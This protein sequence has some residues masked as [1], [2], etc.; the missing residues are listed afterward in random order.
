MVGDVRQCGYMVGI[1]LVK[2]R[3]HQTPF[4]LT[5]RIGHHVSM[6]ARRRGLLIRPIGNVLVLMP[7]LCVTV[8]HLTRMTKILRESIQFIE[9]KRQSEIPNSHKTTFKQQ[10]MTKNIN[11]NR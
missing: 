1:E 3:K 10:S 11:L 9:K 2:D 8:S 7:P 5:D 4:P 6:E